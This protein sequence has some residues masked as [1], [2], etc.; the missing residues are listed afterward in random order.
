M[1]LGEDFN[2]MI[3]AAIFVAALIGTAF[4]SIAGGLIALIAHFIFKFA[5]KSNGKNKDA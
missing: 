3:I 2:N 5:K 4:L 1:W